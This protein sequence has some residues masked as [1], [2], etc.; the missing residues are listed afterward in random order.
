MQSPNHPITHSPN[1]ELWLCGPVP[2]VPPL[3]MPAAHALLQARADVARLVE[4]LTRDQIWQ[5]PG[6]SASIGYHA[7]HLA[8]A[9]D[10]LLTY[11]RGERLTDAQLAAARAEPGASGLEAADVIARVHAQLDAA[12]D[13]IRRTDT[14]T[15]TDARAVGRQ[16]LPSTVL[17][18]IFHAAEH[19]SRHAGQM[20]TLRK[21]VAG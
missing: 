3:L 8:G 7:I 9:A 5:R 10:R 14:A 21:V 6:G 15:L 1:P 13:Q 11:A 2:G 20:A 12:L 18:L 19:A 4:G 17:G 16:Q